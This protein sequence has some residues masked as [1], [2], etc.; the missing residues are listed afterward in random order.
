MLCVC[1]CLRLPAAH[2]FVRVA[3]AA[4]EQQRGGV[5]RRQRRQPTALNHHTGDESEGPRQRGEEREVLHQAQVA[6]H[7]PRRLGHTVLSQT[8]VGRELMKGQRIECM[9]ALWG[10]SYP[11]TVRHL[12]SYGTSYS[13]IECVCVSGIRC[14]RRGTQ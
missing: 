8:K 9:W 6:Q 4:I 2:R 14:V 12:F 13:R 11:S 3:T 5:K 7:V 10:T 1:P